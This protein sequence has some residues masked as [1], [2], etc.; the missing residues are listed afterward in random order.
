MAVRA[1]MMYLE[2]AH[3]PVVSRQLLLPLATACALPMPLL[4]AQPS[5]GQ[6]ASIEVF[7]EQIV[8][9]A[10]KKKTLTHF[11]LAG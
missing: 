1:L 3:A 8:R 5:A 10:T 7:Q 2:A 9:Q 6:T 11:F 4:F